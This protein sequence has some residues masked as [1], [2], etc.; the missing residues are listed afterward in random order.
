[1]HTFKLRLLKSINSIQAAL[2]AIAIILDGS[3]KYQ[4]NS[5]SNAFLLA[6]FELNFGK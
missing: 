2:N 4:G 6:I 3:M 1:M 5:F